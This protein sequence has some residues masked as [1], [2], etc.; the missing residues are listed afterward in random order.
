VSKRSDTL[1]KVSDFGV[2]KILTTGTEMDTHVG[3]QYYKAPE[4]LSNTHQVYT[5][6]VDIWSMGV[7]LYFWYVHTTWVAVLITSFVTKNMKPL[8]SVICVVV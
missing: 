7:M 4:I 2:S 3:T 1:I 5:E 8:M 6:K